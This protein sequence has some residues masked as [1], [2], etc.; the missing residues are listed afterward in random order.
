MYW[1]PPGF[2]HWNNTELQSGPG[3][4]WIY[5]NDESLTHVSGTTQ[6][7]YY[8]AGLHTTPNNWEG[9]ARRSGEPLPGEKG[10]KVRVRASFKI[11]GRTVGS[12][13][14]M[15]QENLGSYY[16]VNDVENIRTVDVS[17]TSASA[18]YGIAMVP[19]TDFDGTISLPIVHSI[20]R[21]G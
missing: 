5:N 2:R 14:M 17:S 20:Q 8:W 4:N 1:T 9:I 11:T 21:L 16:S 13:A 12:C 19:S 6:T 7:H 18:F 10:M 15:I 3:V